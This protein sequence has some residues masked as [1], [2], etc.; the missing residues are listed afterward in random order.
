MRVVNRV[1]AKSRKL[2]SVHFGGLNIEADTAD[3]ATLRVL[4]KGHIEE[5]P[6]GL[7]VS[8]KGTK[9]VDANY[10]K[11]L[12]RSMFKVTLGLIHLDHGDVVS[13]SAR[14][15]PIRRIILGQADFKGFILIRE[16]FEPNRQVS[17]KYDFIEIASHP[18]TWIWFNIFGVQMFTEMEIR[19][20]PP[21]GLMPEK[22]TAFSF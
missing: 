8:F 11:H 10:C 20:F 22:W 19:E 4:D 17:L 1:P 7:S 16:Q 14:F 5:R 9:G 18:G 6:D 3:H 12:A 15:D 21:S 13:L 2:P